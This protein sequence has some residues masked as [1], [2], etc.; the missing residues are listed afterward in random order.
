MATE[1][2]EKKDQ[3]IDP[4]EREYFDELTAKENTRFIVHDFFAQPWLRW[5]LVILLPLVLGFLFFKPQPKASRRQPAALP[6]LKGEVITRESLDRA[7]A[8]TQKDSDTEVQR[9]RQA[10]ASDKK[11]DFKSGMAVFVFEKPD[12]TDESTGVTNMRVRE[13]DHKI[14]IPSGTNIPALLENRIFSFNVAAPV[15]AI[16]AKDFL[17]KGEIAV[18]EGSKFLGEASVLKTLDRIN[19]RFDLLVLPDGTERRIHGIALASDGAGGIKGKVEKHGDIKILKA[20][21][22]TLLGGASLFVGGTRRDP[23]SLE[24]QMR[25]NLS[26]NLTNQAAQDLRSIRVE[27]SVTAEAYTPIQMLLL[28]AI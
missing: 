19:V 4:P 8:I 14:G 17:W 1:D 10:G 20:I 16:V 12:R 25:L 9:R 7:I 18:P 11:R 22:E 27:K 13:T 5:T 6:S 23:F 2:I 15:I 3:K 26:Q 24:D 21:G 28:E